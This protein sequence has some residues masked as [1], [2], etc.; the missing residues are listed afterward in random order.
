MLHETGE[1]FLAG[2]IGAGMRGGLRAILGAA[3]GATLGATVRATFDVA[4]SLI[5]SATISTITSMTCGLLSGPF[6]MQRGFYG[7]RRARTPARFGLKDSSS[8]IGSATIGWIKVVG[9]FLYI[10]HGVIVEHG[11]RFI[12]TASSVNPTIVQK[13]AR[14][15][16]IRMS[17]QA[18][19]AAFHSFLPIPP[20][21]KAVFSLSNYNLARWVIF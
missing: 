1:V 15:R 14:M 4:V 8:T 10:L 9:M 17:Q 20:G 13:G 6:A 3:F 16:H 7:A 12:H 11:Q 19:R 18:H 21:Q 2:S 5:F